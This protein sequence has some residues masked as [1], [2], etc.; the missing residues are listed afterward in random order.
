MSVDRESDA[1][2]AILAKHERKYHR[3]DK[4]SIQCSIYVAWCEFSGRDVTVPPGYLP[5]R[6]DFTDGGWYKCSSCGEM[7]TY[8]Q[9]DFI[10]G[11]PV[12]I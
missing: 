9:I 2:E 12:V 7:H 5:G 4:D 11:K 10:D 6:R 3:R 1:T 8:Y